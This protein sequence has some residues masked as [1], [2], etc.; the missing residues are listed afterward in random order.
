[1]LLAVGDQFIRTSGNDVLPSLCLS[2]YEMT[3]KR[4]A[5]SGSSEGVV[6]VM[7]VAQEWND[8][9]SA[10]SSIVVLSN[11]SSSSMISFVLLILKTIA[12]FPEFRR[13]KRN[14]R[15]ESLTA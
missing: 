10:S 6:F 15:R 8:V 7:P 12:A 11:D 1:M 2:S 4:G 9:P 13:A 14:L 5:D 3:T